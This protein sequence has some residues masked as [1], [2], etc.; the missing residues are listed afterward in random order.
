MREKSYMRAAIIKALENV[1][2]TK[3]L[4]TIYEV[5]KSFQRKA[6]K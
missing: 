5:V 6:E 3:A 2:D 4:S 1:N